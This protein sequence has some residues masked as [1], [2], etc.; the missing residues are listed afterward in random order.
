MAGS[1][2]VP[3]TATSVGSQAETYMFSTTGLPGVTATP[4]VSSFTAT[5]GSVTPW[6]VT[7]LRTTAPLNAY[8][9]G[10]VVWTGDKGHVVTMP[11]V[12]RPVALSTPAEVTSTGAPVNWPVKPGYAGTLNARV[13]GLVEATATPFTLAQD[14]DQTFVPADPTGTFSFS[15]PVPANSL[16][17]A[18][19]YEDAITPTGT[20]LDMYVYLGAS[21]VGV[22]ADGDSN[23]EVTLR[24]GGSGLTLTVYVHGYDT[25][26]PS[27][28]VTLFTWVVPN[29]NNGNATVSGVV[30]PTTI[31]VVQTHTATFAGLTP[32]KRYLGQVDYDNGTAIIGRTIL[33]VRP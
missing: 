32:G 22:S 3:R 14:P 17:R 4:S 10:F 7:F 8:S 16:F 5:P 12:I 9:K 11:V 24:T 31:G 23:E 28:N 2:T 20:D 15:V 18:G 29:V 21:L 19:V 1:Q 6:T 33:N 26:G 25:N 27:A 30:S 13:R